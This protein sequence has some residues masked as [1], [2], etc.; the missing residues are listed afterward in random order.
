MSKRNK[1]HVTPVFILTESY[2]DLLGLSWFK[3][4]HYSLCKIITRNWVYRYTGIE[5]NNWNRFRL[6]IQKSR[7]GEWCIDT[8]PTLGYPERRWII[9]NVLECESSKKYAFV[10][11]HRQWRLCCVKKFN[12]WV[13]VL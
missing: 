1:I 12:I 5:L 11:P 2:T 7:Q 4:D 6:H 13:E 3:S 10:T 8:L 9:N